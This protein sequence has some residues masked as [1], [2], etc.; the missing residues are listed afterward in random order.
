MCE[1]VRVCVCVCAFLTL[2][3][4]QTVGQVVLGVD[5]LVTGSDVTEV[6]GLLQAVG[7]G[8]GL[9]G[10]EAVVAVQLRGDVWRGRKERRRNCHSQHSDRRA[11]PSSGPASAQLQARSVHRLWFHVSSRKGTRRK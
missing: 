3:P 11:R 1:L 6:A 8:K 2:Y 10:E 4:P 7:R 5:G 9:K